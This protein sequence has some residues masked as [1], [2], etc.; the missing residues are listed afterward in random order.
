[1]LCGHVCPMMPLKWEKSSTIENCTF[2]TTGP[3]WTGSMTSPKEVVEAPLKPDSIRLGFSKV[4]D[5]NPIYL[6]V[7]SCNRSAEL[8]GSTTIHLTSK[9]LI[10]N[11]RMRASSCGC[12]TRLG[13]IKEKV[14]TPSIGRV[15]P[16]SK[17]GWMKLTYSLT[18]TTRSNLCLFCLELYFSSMD[19]PL[20]QL[21]ITL[22]AAEVV[23]TWV[24]RSWAVSPR[25]PS[26]RTYCFRCPTLSSFS[27]RQ[28]RLLHCSMVWP[29]SL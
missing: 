8:P 18:E 6:N 19:P 23:G 29:W 13:S 15:P 1:M 25:L 7:D 26:E 16:S 17:P 9:S 12:N 28:W 10:P 4:D 5:G 27:I 24:A 21:I 22:G 3:T 2:Q 14:I 20:M 11:V